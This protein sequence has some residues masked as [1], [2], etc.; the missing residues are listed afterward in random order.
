M[1]IPESEYHVLLVCPKYRDLRI[2]FSHVTVVIGQLIINSKHFMF[3]LK[4]CTRKNCKKYI[5]HA[6]KLRNLSNL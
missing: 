3:K 6:H 4:T 2:K 5:Y 1:N